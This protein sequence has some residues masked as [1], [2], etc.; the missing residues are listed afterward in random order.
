MNHPAQDDISPGMVLLLAAATG[1]IV[2]NL[3]Y[4]QTLV[5]PIS[6]ATGLS[7]Q[8]AGLI[9]TLTQIGYTLGLLFV[10][11][12]GDLLENRRLIVTGLLFTAA[13]L[14]LAALSTSAWMFLTAALGI[15]LGSVAAQI[16]VPFAAHLSKEETRGHTVGKV[17][18][19]LLLGI[20]LARPAAS[21]IADASNWHVVFGGA[22]V[23]VLAVAL[24]LRAKLPLRAPTARIAYPALMAS[25][26]Q[27][28]LRTPLLRRRAA[29]HAGLFG[30]FS[31]FWTV[32]P[33]ML[34]GPQFHLSQT[35]IAVFALVGMAGAV[36]SP[37]AGRLAD[38]GHTLMATAAA[39]ALGVIG[40]ALPLLAPQVPE[41]RNLAL[42]ILVIASIVLDM[43]VA[44]NLVLGQ[45][46]IFTL[47]AEV[48]S[49]LNGV[50]FALFFAGGALGSA[51]GGW[52]FA[53]H[54]WHAALLTGMAFPGLALLYWL[55][56][57]AGHAA[58][59]GKAVV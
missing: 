13:M 16:I 34:A 30:S 50:Y 45:R 53:T 17:V 35:G 1:L 26:W 56:E 29:Y 4:A 58:A 32:T 44:A 39:L 46:A 9:V 36:A 57:Y 14:V 8:A 51:L 41:L 3:Y 22:A 40:F 24:V 2:A 19:G 31:L 38:A 54:G 48:R 47:G 33:L 20:M 27:L 15:G 25:L 43:G 21:L 18:S 42:A 59:S 55:T 49:R 11:P 37:V 12:L 23:L 52:M 5:G 28:F 7:P 10:V 6:A